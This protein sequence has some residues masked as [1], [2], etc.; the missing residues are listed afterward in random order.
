M[1]KEI[2]IT[3]SKKDDLSEWYTQVV[4]KSGLAD[5]ASVKGIYGFDAVWLLD[6]GKNQGIP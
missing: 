3:V 1:S 5:Y 6:L 4:T 2:G